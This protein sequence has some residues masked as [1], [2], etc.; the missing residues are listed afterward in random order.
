VYID[1]SR[2]FHL[3]TS[4]SRQFL[5]EELQMTNEYKS[6]CSSSLAMKEMQ[7]KTTLRFHLTLVKMGIFQNKN[8]KDRMKQE[9]YTVCGNEN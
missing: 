8:N 4:G 3:G 9:L 2:G 7:I 6:K 1:S 5:K